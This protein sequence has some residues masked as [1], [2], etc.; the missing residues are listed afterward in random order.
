MFSWIYNTMDHAPVRIEVVFKKV[1]SSAA[2][3]KWLD[4][5]Q[6]IRSIP[7]ARMIW[8]WTNSDDFWIDFWIDVWPEKN[9]R[10]LWDAHFDGWI[11]H[12]CDGPLKIHRCHRA[13]PAVVDLQGDDA[14]SVSVRIS[15]RISDG[16]IPRY[17]PFQEENMAWNMV[18]LRTSICWILS[19]YHWSPFIFSW[20]NQ[21]FIEFLSQS[22]SHFIHGISC[23]SRWTNSGWKTSIGFHRRGTNT[24]AT[25]L[26]GL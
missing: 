1:P 6:T 5:K 11:W 4:V 16:Y 25:I 12:W 13:D 26:L 22:K 20:N 23:S 15:G 19:H 10:R 3:T 9:Y 14:T 2:G 17:W 18:R 21:F 8:G 24:P 7:G